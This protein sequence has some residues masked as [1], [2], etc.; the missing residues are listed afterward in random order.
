MRRLAQL[1]IMSVALLVGGSAA[2]AQTGSPDNV[3]VLIESASTPA[4]HRAL[5]AH[6]RSKAEE[7]RQQAEK[8]RNM[9]KRYGTTKG[10]VSRKPHCNEIAANYDEIAV[11]SDALAASEEAAAK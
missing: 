3:E 2:F 5:A 4:E 10:G 11:Q 1:V 7:A 9:A 6:F 8:H